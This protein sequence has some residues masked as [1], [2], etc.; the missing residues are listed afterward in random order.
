MIHFRTQSYS[1]IPHALERAAD[2]VTKAH[3]AQQQTEELRSQ[4]DRLQMICEGMWTII[5]THTA[6]TDED[7]ARLVEQI[8][9]RD[10]KING[11][12]ASI[13][14]N[15]SSCGRVVSVRTLVCLYCGKQN[16]K[17]SVF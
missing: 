6:A 12:T 10:G 9:L 11:K 7:L 17:S 2:A 16:S 8:D 1:W 14:Q 4:V 5:K 15:C 13:P 3:E